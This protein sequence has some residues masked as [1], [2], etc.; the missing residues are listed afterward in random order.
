MRTI[1]SLLASGVVALAA[2]GCEQSST[3][4][5]N[6]P[7][8]DYW[9]TS[10]AAVSNPA[11]SHMAQMDSTG[12][13]GITD[14]KVKTIQD[15]QLGTPD[16]VARMHG[17]QKIQYAMLGAFLTDLG[18]TMTAT[19]TAK[20]GTES[21]G[22]LY[23]SGT[24]ALGAP[25]F[26]SRTPEMIIPSTSALAKEY[27][28]FM[29][30]APEI[31]ANIGSSTRCNGVELI[32]AGEL[33]QDGISCLIGKPA[34]ADHVQLASAIVAGASTPTNG[35]EIAVATLLAAAHISE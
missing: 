7:A 3:D 18:A 31:I 9:S 32:T 33:T 21:A 23:T 16:Q 8:T 5:L 14:P 6:L 24:D 13:N 29:A 17:T 26:A 2:T 12:Q 11:P 4:S 35:Q 28:I 22:T 10:A 34:T 20:G 27:D 25:I 19:T 30:A 1:I 15:A